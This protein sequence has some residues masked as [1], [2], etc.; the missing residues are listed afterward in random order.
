FEA[1]R[2]GA[3]TPF[4]GRR[5]EMDLLL[6][7]WQQAKAGEGRVVL[8]SGE[9]GIG[10]SRITE[11]LLARIEGEP[12]ARFRYFC[13]PHQASA[14]LHP[15]IAQ[16]AQAASFPPDSSAGVKLDKLA[17]LLEPTSTNLARD[18][19]LVAELLTIP[20]DGRYPSVA[21]TPQQKREMT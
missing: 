5:E 4:V 6:R 10:K 21:V 2:R 15:F 3:I 16:L 12:H 7:R 9:P 1:R 8:L 13:S 18:V 17:S 19:A 20:L 11:S 14:P